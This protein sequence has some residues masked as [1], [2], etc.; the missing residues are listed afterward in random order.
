VRREGKSSRSLY[1]TS[2]PK[3]PSWGTCGGHGRG[4][5]VLTT[6]ARDP[7]DRSATCNFRAV[8][9]GPGKRQDVGERAYNLIQAAGENPEQG[10]RQA[11]VR[12]AAASDLASCHACSEPC[13]TVGTHRE[14]SLESARALDAMDDLEGAAERTKD[15]RRKG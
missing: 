6:I 8:Q 7:L 2:G 13:P 3:G 12:T 11:G 1:E 14:E 15:E 5:W 4:R 9:K 10:R